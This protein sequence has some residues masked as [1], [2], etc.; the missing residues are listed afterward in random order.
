MIEINATMTAYHVTVKTLD[1]GAVSLLS[2]TRDKQ[3]KNL[4]VQ[5]NKLTLCREM[6]V[7]YE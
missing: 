7:L 3:F 5:Y 1:D 4:V 2:M 6:E